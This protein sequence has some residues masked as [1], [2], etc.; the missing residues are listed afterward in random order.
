MV[1]ALCQAHRGGEAAASL[2]QH[3]WAAPLELLGDKPAV[4]EYIKSKLVEL[5]EAV[6][7]HLTGPDPLQRLSQNEMTLF[8]TLFDAHPFLP[9]DCAQ[10][11]DAVVRLSEDSEYVLRGGDLFSSSPKVLLTAACV[12]AV[13][14]NAIKCEEG[15][16]IVLKL[17]ARTVPFLDD[18]VRQLPTLVSSEGGWL[19]FLYSEVS[20][21]LPFTMRARLLRLEGPS[22]ASRRGGSAAQRSAVPV[23]GEGRG[24]RLS[25]HEQIQ[26]IAENMVALGGN[27]DMRNVSDLIA[28]LSEIME[29]SEGH[30]NGDF[31]IESLSSHYL[32]VSRNRLLSS[33]I[34]GDF[35]CLSL[36]KLQELLTKR[37]LA[38]EFATDEDEQLAEEEGRARRRRRVRVDIG[39]GGGVTREWVLLF[40]NDV[41]ASPLF[42]TKDG[43]RTFHP[44][45]FVTREE[46]LQL[47]VEK[48]VEEVFRIIGRMLGV[49]VVENVQLDAR[50]SDALI[51]LMCEAE[52]NEE[53]LAG[54]DPA[55]YDTKVR[56]LRQHSL[57]ELGFVTD[58]DHPN[59]FEYGLH[60]VATNRHGVEVPLVRGGERMIVND[61]TKDSYVKAATCFHL[62][63]AHYDSE[64]DEHVGMSVEL[65][66][67]LGGYNEV[68]SAKVVAQLGLGMEELKVCLFGQDRVDTADWKANT[69]LAPELVEHSEMVA[70]WW[71]VVEEADERERRDILQFS[72]GNPRVP[73]GGFA[74]L[75]RDNGSLDTSGRKGFYIGLLQCEGDPNTF[76]PASQTCFNTI[77]LPAYTSKAMLQTQMTK[78]I[79]L[80]KIGFGLC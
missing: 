78:A 39:Q 29:R 33:T 69:T 1:E 48:D 59:A 38:V 19:D 74:F 43:G 21:L 47:G 34:V 65:S 72:T 61:G 73:V 56:H 55:L 79:A 51:K 36:E 30:Q 15:R 12:R 14:L 64:R 75:N 63:G 35:G 3:H 66:S 32:R 40:F 41:C 70:W 71:E 6:V 57:A 28:R 77:R 37:T 44:A 13:Y 18:V 26:I 10:L 67:L 54:V 25:S 80:T 46:L 68:I 16:Q 22:W 53:D 20:S 8:C 24:E 45:S 9:S 76:L 50:L 31:H 60:F 52:V 5:K 42:E 2:A 23:H 17:F 58:V 11:F 4:Q 27:Q 7:K 62:L 49:A